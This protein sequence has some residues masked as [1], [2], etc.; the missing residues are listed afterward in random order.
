MRLIRA[1]A[2]LRGGRLKVESRV[3][4]KARWRPLTAG[5]SPGNLRFRAVCL[6]S[7]RGKIIDALPCA[8]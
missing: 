2:L 3:N 6:F 1:D 7:S 5:L 8:H 4:M